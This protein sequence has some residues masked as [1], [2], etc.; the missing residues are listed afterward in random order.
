M[1]GLRAGARRLHGS[2]TFA[3]GA[4]RRSWLGT[5]PPPHSQPHQSSFPLFLWIRPV[6]DR[7]NGRTIMDQSLDLAPPARNAPAG[8]YHDP[9][10]GRSER[11]ASSSPRDSRL[12]KTGQPVAVALRSSN[13]RLSRSI[14]ATPGFSTVASF[15]DRTS[16]SRFLRGALDA[17]SRG[18]PFHRF[19]TGRRNIG[20]RGC[21]GLELWIRQPMRGRRGRSFA[22]ARAHPIRP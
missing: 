15:V 18:R 9:A 13:L 2:G 10:R 16:C 19:G 14:P 5:T 6:A 20:R 1:R 3:Q 12:Q 7:R 4:A 22:E 11:N 17:F 21:A 8:L